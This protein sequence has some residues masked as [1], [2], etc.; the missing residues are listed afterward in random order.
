[1]IKIFRILLFP[2]TIVYGLIVWIRNI[3]FDIGLF[4]QVRFSVPI[5]SVGNLAVGG[6]GKT[7]VTE[8]LVELTKGKRVAILS[9]GYGRHTKGFRVV[10][11]LDS[12]ET[13]G[14]EPMQ[15]FRKFTDVT[16]AVCEKR[17]NGIRELKD[18]HDLIIL[19]DAFQHRWVQPGLSILLFDHSKIGNRILLPT[20]NLREP[21]RNYRRADILLITKIPVE[22][23]SAAMAELAKPF[24]NKPVFFSSVRYGELR[25]TADGNL[26]DITHISPKTNVILITAIADARPMVNFIEKQHHVVKHFEFTDHHLFTEAN[27]VAFTKEFNACPQNSTIIVTTEKDAQRLFN[28]NLRKLLVN[29]PVHILPIKIEIENGS[30]SD[31]DKT[32]L[33]YVAGATRNT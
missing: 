2:I 10:N 12:A 5:I 14:D 26:G 7:P 3:F 6:S 33:E 11:D 17:V 15:Y 23:A 16:V 22:T 30:K 20:G 21:F 27:I 9:R 31:F 4:T 32:I 29:L 1:M 28:R 25:A 24:K 8:Y 13:V 18:S 19:D